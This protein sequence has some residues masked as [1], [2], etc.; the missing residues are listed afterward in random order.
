MSKIR[1]D[2]RCI[3]LRT[4]TKEELVAAKNQLGVIRIGIENQLAEARYKLHATGER[5]DPE[6]FRRATHAHKM[7][8][9]NMRQIDEELSARKRMAHDDRNGKNREL[10][11]FFIDVAKRKLT[12]EQY[13]EIWQEAQEL[14]KEYYKT[15]ATNEVE[16]ARDSLA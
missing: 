14:A 12:G 5:S 6:W 4:V 15:S 9:V 10:M 13:E 16:G 3:D 1:V 11:Q 7:K 2:G 8:G